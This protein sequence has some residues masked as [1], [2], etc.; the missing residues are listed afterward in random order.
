MIKYK[1]RNF[2]TA[3]FY[4]S[5]LIIT[6]YMKL[7][8]LYIFVFTTKITKI[9]EILNML[10]WLHFANIRCA[11]KSTAKVYHRISMFPVYYSFSLIHLLH[12]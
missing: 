1:Y 6:L 11:V 12:I 8:L 10:S 7:F 2:L 5:Y 9:I 3:Y 4:I